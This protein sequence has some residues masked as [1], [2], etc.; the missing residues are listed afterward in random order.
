MIRAFLCL[1]DWGKR[2]LLTCLS[3]LELFVH[4]VLGRSVLGPSLCLRVRVCSIQQELLYVEK[5]RVR[6]VVLVDRYLGI[7]WCLHTMVFVYKP[8]LLTAPVN[9]VCHMGMV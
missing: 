2:I 5:P 7:P 8:W 9:M 1:G 3:L 6:P 4:H